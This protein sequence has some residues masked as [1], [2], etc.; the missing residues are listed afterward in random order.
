MSNTDTVV[1]SYLSGIC[2]AQLS[3]VHT[4]LSDDS[5]LVSEPCLNV[6]HPA[7]W[8]SKKLSFE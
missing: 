8:Y 7:N 4:L 5:F 2:P 6:R 1:S 3:S